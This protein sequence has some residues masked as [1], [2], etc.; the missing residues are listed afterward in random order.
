M[1]KPAKAGSGRKPRRLSPSRRKLA[2]I[3]ALICG[4]SL[5][6]GVL[7]FDRWPSTLGDNAEFAILGISLASGRGFR[8]VN[9]PE[10]RPATKYPPGFPLMVAGWIS[11]FG[12]TILSMKTLVLVCYLAAMA[13]TYLVARK[14]L[15]GTLSLLAV[16]LAVSSYTVLSY[17]HQILSDIPYTLFSLLAL[18]LLLGEGR[19][20]TS[21]LV[22]ISISLWAYLVRTVGVSLV[23]AVFVLLLHRHRRREAIALAAS[24]V[25]VSVLWAVRNYTMTGEGNRYLGVLLSADP[26]APD[27][28]SISLGGLLGRG[29]TNLSSYVGSLLPADLF[30]SLVFGSGT[31]GTAL[32]GLIS[33]MITAVACFGGYVLRKRALVVNVYVLGYFA[34]Y[35]AWPEI[36]KSERFMVPIAPI[37]GIY[38]F[39]GINRLLAYFDVKRAVTLVVCTILVLSN[40]ISLQE[41]V[42]RDRGYPPGWNNYFDTAMWVRDNTPEDTLVLCRKPF[43]FYVFSRRRTIAYP[44]TSDRQV[45]RDYLLEAKPDYIILEDFGGVSTTEV[46]VVPVLQGMLPYLEQLYMT[47]EPSNT[48]L[49]F[50]WEEAASRQ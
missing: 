18:L 38:F 40:L 4:A 42:R 21:M 23:F 8:Y 47:G 5:L 9:H 20:R 6:A 1:P 39:A 46:Y 15:D 22:A 2:L 24:F 3:I 37:V 14:L 48:V 17:S 10:E 36:W 12:N 30:P 44:F 19:T 41:F 50:F 28:G 35:L 49:R 25:A 29:W 13:V 43:L 31:R 27:K 26:Y 45:M 34:V 32:G 11:I 33:V 7:G 16:F